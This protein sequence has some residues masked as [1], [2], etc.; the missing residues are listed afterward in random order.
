MNI[1]KK[2]FVC[3]T[4]KAQ[5]ALSNGDRSALAAAPSQA[6]VGSKALNW[7]P[8]SQATD[9]TECFWG[10][11]APLAPLNSVVSGLGAGL[12]PRAAFGALWLLLKRRWT[13]ATAPKNH[14]KGELRQI[15]A[16]RVLGTNC[17]GSS[18]ELPECNR[19]RGTTLNLLSVHPC[20][21]RAPASLGHSRAGAISQARCP[22]H[23]RGVCGVCAAPDRTSALLW[24]CWICF[25]VL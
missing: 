11:Q 7:H 19:A 9:F 12:S 16:R 13:F 24:P 14:F 25:N 1:F 23:R 18:S 15:R 8:Q 5:A 20:A 17:W 3:L 6:R 22:G 10:F 2:R 21:G 4:S